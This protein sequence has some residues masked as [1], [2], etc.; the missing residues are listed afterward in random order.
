ME[1]QLAE[2]KEQVSA[3]QK[4]VSRVAGEH[5]SVFHNLTGQHA[6]ARAR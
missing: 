5:L 6:Q 1:K 2:L 3:L 4:E